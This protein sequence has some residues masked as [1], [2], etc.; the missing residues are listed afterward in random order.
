MRWNG[1]KR[2]ADRGKPC[3]SQLVGP[4]FVLCLGRWRG[5]AL[6][7]EMA[8]WARPSPWAA[9]YFFVWSLCFY[10]STG[11]AQVKGTVHRALWPAFCSAVWSRAVED[12]TYPDKDCWVVLKTHWFN[13]LVD[14]IWMN[15]FRAALCDLVWGDTYIQMNLCAQSG[16]M[17][18]N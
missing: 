3:V 14:F 9:V 5:T 18:V 10:F 11:V 1:L 15:T 16:A 8:R 4:C 13:K 7:V 17:S 12:N 2:A 6:P